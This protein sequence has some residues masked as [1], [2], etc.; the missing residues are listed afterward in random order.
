MSLRTEIGQSVPPMNPRVP[1]PRIEIRRRRSHSSR[2]LADP[3][4]LGAR[5]HAK[6]QWFH[7]SEA[8]LRLANQQTGCDRD[9]GD[10]LT[11]LGVDNQGVTSASTCEASVTSTGN[12]ASCDDSQLAIETEP[13][14]LV[15]KTPKDRSEAALSSARARA[16]ARAKASGQ[17]PK[18]A[19]QHGS[20]I[21]QQQWLAAAMGAAS[22]QDY[23]PI[24]VQH[25][26]L[27][28][29]VEHMDLFDDI[30][31]LPQELPPMTPIASPRGL[32]NLVRTSCASR[33]S[34]E[35]APTAASAAQAAAW[36][37]PAAPAASLSPRPPS[38]SFSCHQ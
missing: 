22:E 16:R 21:A 34:S 15:L 18:T 24:D 28:Q 4:G 25:D 2:R 19:Q 32:L 9:V 23:A 5:L 36:S 10:E 30:E 17:D 27:T 11:A 6:P 14:T 37:A 7:A 29:F 12:V 13:D 26:W 20:V 1:R 8:S 33:R 31:P 3:F 35:S 38:P